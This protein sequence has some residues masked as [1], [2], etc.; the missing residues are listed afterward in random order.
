MD[1]N[2]EGYVGEA[3]VTGFG[4][5]EIHIR[6]SYGRMRLRIPYKTEEALWEKY[7]VDDVVHVYLT[8]GD[9]CAELRLKTPPPPAAFPSEM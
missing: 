9:G 6:L 4:I 7:Q 1:N 5:N 3:L 2:P 8:A